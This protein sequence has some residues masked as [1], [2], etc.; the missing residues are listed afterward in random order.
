M[1]A[2]ARNPFRHR[3]IVPEPLGG[4]GS[5]RRMTNRATRALRGVSNLENFRNALGAGRF[6]R[7]IRPR[8]MKIVRGPDRILLAL[9]AR[10]AVA[11]A[12]AAGLRAKE[13]GF[14]KT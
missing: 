11:T 9:F 3:N 12:G 1:A 10:A 4:H 13:F 7:G 6:E 8:V 5:K 2:L 14:Q